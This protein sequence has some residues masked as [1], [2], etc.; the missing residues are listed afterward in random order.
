MRF[1]H[2]PE[3]QDKR[4]ETNH[5]DQQRTSMRKSISSAPTRVLKSCA[6]MPGRPYFVT[7]A[8]VRPLTCRSAKQRRTRMVHIFVHETRHETRVELP[9]RL[10]VPKCEKL[11]YFC[12]T[13]TNE[14]HLQICTNRRCR[15]QTSVIMIILTSKFKGIPI[16]PRRRRASRDC[17]FSARR[18]RATGTVRR[19]WAPH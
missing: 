15:Q 4:N 6:R 16:W 5:R 12:H 19:N 11:T 1:T 9:S 17:T 3:K 18:R 10:Q 13:L 2:E 8:S 7:S 14:Q